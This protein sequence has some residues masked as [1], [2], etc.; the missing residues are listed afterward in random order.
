MEEKIHINKFTDNHRTR[1]A[2][3]ILAE[4]LSNFQRML[5]VVEADEE[6]GKRNGGRK[7]KLHSHVKRITL[8]FIF[9]FIYPRA[10]S[11]TISFR[12]ERTSEKGTRKWEKEKI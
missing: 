11:L 8:K 1:Q 7:K 6:S 10:N 12:V 5:S 9:I 2:A 4:I 3:A